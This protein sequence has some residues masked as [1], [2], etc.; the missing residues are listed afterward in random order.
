MPPKRCEGGCGAMQVYIYMDYTHTYVCIRTCV[1]TYM[2]ACIRI[3]MCTH[4]CIRTR[5]Y[6]FMHVHVYVYTHTCV[7]M[8]TH[9]CVYVDRP[10]STSWGAAA[11]RLM[12]TH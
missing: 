4:V 2:H 10:S 3:R 8:C 1:R 9:M 7:Y 11:T 5:V 12:T 6:I